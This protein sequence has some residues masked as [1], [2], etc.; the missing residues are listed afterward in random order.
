LE[1]GHF[2]SSVPDIAL[3][4]FP[5]SHNTPQEIVAILAGLGYK[6]CSTDVLKT[7]LLSVMAGFWVALA[8]ILATSVAGGVPED[9][10][11]SW[12]S[13]PRTLAATVFPVGIIFEVLFGGEL[14]T[15]NNMILFVSWYSGRI[16]KLAVAGNWAVVWLGN[17]AGSLSTLVMFAWLPGLFDDDPFRGFAVAAAEMR[18]ALSHDAIFLRGV[19]ANVL[20]C[21]SIYLGLMARDVIG[22]AFGMYIPIFV[23]VATAMEHCVADMYFVPMGML[24][25][26]KV[27]VAACVL[28]LLTCTAGNIVGGAL[29]VGGSLWY[30]HGREVSSVVEGEKFDEK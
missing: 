29:L 4:E 14:F 25:G 23:F 7:F 30:M 26:A 24:L 6:K 27:D 19:L 11:V 17:L 5:R 1:E 18:G 20:V 9:V 16:S 21:V 13:L 12:P 3:P 28:F 10:R 8:G 15:G 2:A 22:K